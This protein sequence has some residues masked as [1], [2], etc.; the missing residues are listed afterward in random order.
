LQDALQHHFRCD[1]NAVSIDTASGNAPV[2]KV[3]RQRV[4]VSFSYEQ[5]WAFIA[6]DVRRPIG[7][8]VT[9]INHEAEWI[10]ECVRVAK[11]FLPPAISRKIE[12]LAGLERDTAFAE[13]WACMKQN[14]NVWACHSKNR[15][16]N[17][18]FS[19]PKCGQAR[20]GTSKV[21]WSPLRGTKNW[22]P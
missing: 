4:H 11:E 6:L 1:A 15:Q 13:E 20:S 22:K 2:V 18:R 17:S 19:W 5:D 7:I 9:F 14:L 10:E 8:D 21:S 3:G 12:G 16:A